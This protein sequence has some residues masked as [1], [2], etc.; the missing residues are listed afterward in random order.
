MPL[1]ERQ[2]ELVNEANK[3]INQ[4]QGYSDNAQKVTTQAGSEY[5][6]H[7][8]YNTSDSR[9]QLD[10][11]E[12]DMRK[13]IESL[14]KCIDDL[15]IAGA[16]KETIDG[17][18]KQFISI[19]A[20]NDLRINIKGEDPIVISEGQTIPGSY[21]TRFESDPDDYESGGGRYVT[22]EITK[23]EKIEAVVESRPEINLTYHFMLKGRIEG[24]T[25]SVAALYKKGED[26]IKMEDTK[27]VTE[28]LLEN[29][30]N[31]QDKKPINYYNL[32]VLVEQAEKE[33]KKHI[34]NEKNK[35]MRN[36]KLDIRVEKLN[37]NSEMLTEDTKKMLEVFEGKKDDIFNDE[38]KVKA[39]QKN[40]DIAEK[41]VVAYTAAKKVFDQGRPG[42]S[43]NYFRLCS[44]QEMAALQAKYDQAKKGGPEDLINY[45]NAC[46]D[47]YEKSNARES[48]VGSSIRGKCNIIT[49]GEMSAQKFNDI[50]TS[51][52]PAST[53]SESFN[54]AS[55]QFVNTMK[56]A[57]TQSQGKIVNSMKIG[58]SV[59]NFNDMHEALRDAVVHLYNSKN[60]FFASLS[61]P[62]RG[63]KKSDT[64][65]P[66]M[67]YLRAAKEFLEDPT[68]QEKRNACINFEFHTPL[69]QNSNVLQLKKQI[70]LWDCFS[71]EGLCGELKT[72]PSK[73]F[74]G[75]NN[76][77]ASS[78]SKNRLK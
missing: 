43:N 6:N 51:P 47:A 5:K 75:E 27:G 18:I 56:N 38:T 33:N 15:C 44:D 41:Q 25:P 21:E 37:Q 26:F 42:F 64:P 16:D 7:Y 29:I 14:Q 17:L 13:A 31:E 77:S 57:F 61:N 24:V 23:P 46:V 63:L 8:W 62:L 40:L 32:G 69:E 72:L 53:S 11:I 9:Y 12:K 66:K 74:S 67:D 19:E 70:E 49:S 50:M 52:F 39:L 71:K 68:N 10:K 58:N 76:Q 1:T 20:A 35:I 59:Q 73:P 48:T 55:E 2:S 30:K 78:S 45:H 54:G 22:V 36:D 3:L 60:T 34:E 4:L 28:T 65:D